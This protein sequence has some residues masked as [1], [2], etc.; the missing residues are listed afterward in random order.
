MARYLRTLSIKVC[1]L[2]EPPLF[3]V[4]VVCYMKCQFLE[5]VQLLCPVVVEKYPKQKQNFNYLFYRA[6]L[7]QINTQYYISRIESEKATT[8]PQI[9]HGFGESCTRPQL[10][11]CAC[12]Q[13]WSTRARRPPLKSYEKAFQGSFIQLLWRQLECLST[14]PLPD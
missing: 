12:A 9:K 5:A 14:P 1:V 11:W 7:S 2:G 13:F 8:H 10:V 6:A 3:F 4:I